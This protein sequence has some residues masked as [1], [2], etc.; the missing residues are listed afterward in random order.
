MQEFTD[1][2]DLLSTIET[3]GFGFSLNGLEPSSFSI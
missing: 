3:K 1:L 2:L